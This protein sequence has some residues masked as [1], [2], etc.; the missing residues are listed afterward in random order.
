[1]AT[2]D[3]RLLPLIETL[4][5]AGA[6]WL[7][8]ELIETL[9]FGRWPEESEDILAATRA[10][11]REGAVQKRMEE[12]VRKEVFGREI[13]R[14]EQVR[15]AAAFVDDRIGSALEHLS[16]SLGNLDAIIGETPNDTAVAKQERRPISLRLSGSDD[17]AGVAALDIEKARTGMEALRAALTRWANE[18]DGLPA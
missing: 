13:P 5:G 7:A 10:Q 11:V 4:I 2:I 16:G 18:A 15:W 1:M 12:P 17:I 3:P 8:I 6:D 9:S 14:E